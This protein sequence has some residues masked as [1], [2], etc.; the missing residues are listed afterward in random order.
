LV[1]YKIEI[2]KFRFALTALLIAAALASAGC[3]SKKVAAAQARAA[4]L[5]GQRDAM[6]QMVQQ[7][8]SQVSAEQTPGLAAIT[9]ITVIGPV[10]NPVVP[11]TKGL[12]LAQAIVIAVYH[13]PVDPTMIVIKRP[14]QEIQ[15]EPSR[16]LNGGDFPLAPGDIIQFQLPPQ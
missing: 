11:W 9:N 2:M 14:H 13:S 15:I 12:T 8:T 4:Y 6:T 7:S 10:E 3:V 1:V 16:L 5:A